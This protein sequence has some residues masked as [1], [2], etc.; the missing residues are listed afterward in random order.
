MPVVIRFEQAVYGSFPF[1][2]KGYAILARSPGCRD[3]WLADLKAACQ[4]YGERPPHAAEAGGLM[5]MRLPSGPWAIVRPSSQGSDDRGRPGAMA[6]HALFLSGSD[7]RKAGAFPFEFA[8]SLHTDWTPDT[9]LSSGSLTLDT[10]TYT[11]TPDGGQ[12]SRIAA[13]LLR[14][15]RVAIESEGPIDDL[16]RAVW[17][18]LPARR[19]ARLSLATWTYANGNRHDL[20]ALPRLAGVAL[21]PSYVDPATLRHPRD[22]V[23]DR[24]PAIPLVGVIAWSAFALF[25]LTTLGFA[26]LHRDRTDPVTPAVVSPAR[27]GSGGTPHHPFNSF[28][29]R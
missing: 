20:A 4:R 12:A 28:Q 29:R 9:S 11:P 22:S 25:A 2:D 1:W 13:A 14:G 16:A 27:A 15:R 7:Y 5:A 6:F 21:D 23:E 17:L 26:W 8:S 10:P 3:E 18:A 24:I 19:R